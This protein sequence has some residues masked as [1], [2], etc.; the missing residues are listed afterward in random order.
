MSKSDQRRALPTQDL[1][2]AYLH[3]KAN[4]ISEHCQLL[5]TCACCGVMQVVLEGAGGEAP[6][7]EPPETWNH[8]HLMKKEVPVMT[9]VK[10]LRDLRP[11]MVNLRPVLCRFLQKFRGNISRKDTN[12][13]FRTVMLV[14]VRKVGYRLDTKEPSTNG[15]DPWDG[16]L[17]LWKT[18]G[19]ACDARDV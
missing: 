17:L 7:V 14:F 5:M 4:L 6:G 12:H 19:L 1:P 11:M 16:L 13:I 10:V 9:N 18:Q 2:P 3:Q 15:F 8:R